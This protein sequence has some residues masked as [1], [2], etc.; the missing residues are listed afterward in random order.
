MQ[1]S[2]TFEADWQR[3]QSI[4]SSVS[5]GVE[6]ILREGG[7]RDAIVMVTGELLENAVKYGDPEGSL[8]DYQL[9]VQ[10]GAAHIR[11]RSKCEPTSHDVLRLRRLIDELSQVEP[12]QIEELYHRRLLELCTSE[13]LQTGLGL[14]RIAY[15]GGARLRYAV[16]EAQ[17]RLEVE[18]ELKGAA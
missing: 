4:R 17:S 15:E 8:V 12:A 1:L 11:V 14:V 7:F 18:A 10:R 5:Q 13:T 3:A 2:V 9:V 6:S 16:D